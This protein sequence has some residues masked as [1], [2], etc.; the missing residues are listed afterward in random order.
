MLFIIILCAVVILFFYCVSPALRRHP[1]SQ[2][3]KNLFVAHRGLHSLKDGIPENSITAIK[4]AAD[5][6]YGVEIDIHITLDGKVVVFH[7]DTLMRACGVNKRIKN[8]TYDELCEFKLFGTQEKIPTLDEVL[9]AVDG[10]TMLVIEF[11]CSDV[12]FKRLCTA[13][14]K[15]LRQ[16]SGKYIVQSFNPLPMFWYRHNRPDICRGQLSTDFFRQ[17]KNNALKAAAG[18]LILNMISRPDFISYDMRYVKAFPRKICS[19][20]GAIRA[21]WTFTELSQV[22]R[23]KKNFDIYIFEGFLPEI[24]KNKN[25]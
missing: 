4:R 21:G 13:A 22:E 9:K 14:D 16:Y 7:D 11:K 2:L 6:G 1:N 19:F 24:K 20:L 25:P 3:C 17:P 18:L 12:S 5:M 8:L 10:R 23:V 15:L